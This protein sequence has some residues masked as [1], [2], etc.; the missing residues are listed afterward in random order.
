MD[1]KEIELLARK[2]GKM[3]KFLKSMTD[4]MLM[5]QIA[6]LL[7]WRLEVREEPIIKYGER[8]NS[9][10]G[11][12]ALQVWIAPNGTEHAIS[13]LIP[14]ELPFLNWLASTDNALRL[15]PG[16][17]D[18]VKITVLPNKVVV[19]L[20][21]GEEKYMTPFEDYRLPRALCE[22]FFV[23]KYYSNKHKNSVL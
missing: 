5:H 2:H 13:E 10:A 15:F 8:D 21:Y 18:C 14:D 17:V 7:G 9:I 6:K 23:W 11:Y 12:T 1:K 22:A 3:T 4:D 16:R 19:R 20:G